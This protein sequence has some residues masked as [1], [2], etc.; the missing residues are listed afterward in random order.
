MKFSLFFKRQPRYTEEDM[1][2]FIEAARKRFEN[3]E[4]GSDLQ[5]FTIPHRE[6]D[7]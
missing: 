2:T 5:Q 6:E 4:I 1:G 3:T 7:E